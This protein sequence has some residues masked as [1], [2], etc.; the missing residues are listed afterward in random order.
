MD[1]P[2]VPSQSNAALL[3]Q[4][5]NFAS[6]P[7]D[8]AI[9]DSVQRSNPHIASLSSRNVQYALSVFAASYLSA[10]CSRAAYYA[11]ST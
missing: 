3:S 2:E 5:P 11:T 10:L 9:Y 4:I 7:S 1:K 8:L 6:A